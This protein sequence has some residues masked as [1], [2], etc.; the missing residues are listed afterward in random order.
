MIDFI[1]ISVIVV[2]ITQARILLSSPVARD[3]GFICS[4][5]SEVL[6]TKNTPHFRIPSPRNRGEIPHFW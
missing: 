3:T 5:P 1:A 6:M 2:V 4:V